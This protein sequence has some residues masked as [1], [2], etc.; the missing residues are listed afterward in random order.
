[1]IYRLKKKR[2]KSHQKEKYIIFSI[3]SCVFIADYYSKMCYTVCLHYLETLNIP[4]KAPCIEMKL[5]GVKKGTP[6][7]RF[8]NVTLTIFQLKVM[9]M[10]YFVLSK[11]VNVL[12]KGKSKHFS[13][14][15]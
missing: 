13:S 7:T 14:S 2:G 12:Y 1:M 11:P 6:N 8:N 15:L 5:S 9:Q 3:S 4:H 10:K